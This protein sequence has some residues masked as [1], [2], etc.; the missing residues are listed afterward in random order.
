MAG[1]KRASQGR[2]READPLAHIHRLQQNRLFRNASGTFF[3]EGVRNFVRAVDHKFEF[4]TLVFSEKLLTVPVARKLLRQK[5]REGVPCASLNPEQF[6]QF[7][8]TERASGI[9]A[10]VRQ[11]WAKLSEI[12]P[13]EGLCWVILDQ[14]RSAG[15]F[16]TLI[17]T[18]DAVGAAGFIL[19]DNQVDP[20]APDVVRASMG[21][22]F[23]QQFV[24][25]TLPELQRWMQLSD[26][27]AIGASPDGTADLHQF[28]YSRSS[29]LFLGEERKGLTTDQRSLCR[30]FIRIP[31]VGTADSLNLAVAGSLMMYEMLRGKREQ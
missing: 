28:D 24:R 9:G 16:G 15:N 19:L 30:E 26:C 5:R 29:L 27:W 1:L 18:A 10:I 2:G 22:L 31:M 11:R 12:S 7:S 17:R 21:S 23:A 14:V 4:E 6:R 20:F 25:T 13:D 3:V 8:R